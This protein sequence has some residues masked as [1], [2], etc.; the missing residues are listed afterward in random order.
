MTIT[1]SP[2]AHSHQYG[3]R[4][5]IDDFERAEFARCGPLGDEIGKVEIR[6]GG[7][8]GPQ[9]EPGLITPKDI[10]CERG[11]TSSLDVYNWLEQVRNGTSGF[12]RTATVEEL[13]LDGSVKKRWTIEACWPTDVELGSWDNTANEAVIEK[14][15]LCNEGVT[16]DTGGSVTL[17]SPF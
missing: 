16:L 2:T 15:T 4:L 1:G 5:I 13:N 9:Y 10:I 8:R 14:F 11:K 17:P 6:E 7:R 12:R 3:F